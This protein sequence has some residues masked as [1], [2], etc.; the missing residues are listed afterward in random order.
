MSDVSVAS[1]TNIRRAS[2]SRSGYHKPE[3]AWILQGIRRQKQLQ[4]ARVLLYDHGL[5]REDHTLKSLALQLL[6]HIEDLRAQ[7]V[8][9]ETDSQ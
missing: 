4:K 7:E 2:T 3:P 8:G 6:Q 9:F 5:P 1:P